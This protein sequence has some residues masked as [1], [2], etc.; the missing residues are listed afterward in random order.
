MLMDVN[1][2]YQLSHMR[3]AMTGIRNTWKN[4]KKPGIEARACSKYP[5]WASR[6]LPCP[7][8]HL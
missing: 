8:K 2:G 3:Q 5:G 1:N 4:F 6:S 7:K